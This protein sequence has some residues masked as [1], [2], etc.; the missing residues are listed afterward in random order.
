MRALMISAL[1]LATGCGAAKAPQS[2]ADV[3]LDQLG[4]TCA[5]G[6]LDQGC[7][8]VSAGF[9]NDA[10]GGAR[11]YWQ[12]QEGA[13]A[14]DGVGGG[15]V[16]FSATGDRLSPIASD[17]DASRYEAPRFVRQAED[18]PPLLVANGTSRG[19]GASPMSFVWR[20][21]DS[22]WIK[23]DTDAW[24]SEAEARLGKSAIQSGVRI[25]F[26]EMQA[27]TPLWRENDGHCCPSGGWARLEFEVRDGVIHLTDARRLP[28]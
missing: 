28:G 16:M 20:W 25:D 1:V 17:F 5:I 14:N 10:P 8:V 3:A 7:G 18:G 11:L 22:R 27:I 9:L 24:F 19:T 21:Q 13:S 15:L 4:E 23:V 12:I 6:T 2:P 26:D